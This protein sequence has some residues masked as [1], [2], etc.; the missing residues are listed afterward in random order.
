MHPLRQ[1]VGTKKVILEFPEPLLER[2]DALARALN[3]D[4]S[5]FIRAAVEEKLERLEREQLELALKRAYEVKAKT[6]L[7][8][9]KDFEQT[10]IELLSRASG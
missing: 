1:Q 5:K 9:Y 8:L 2:T 6:A 4:R 10:Q 3:S 7:E